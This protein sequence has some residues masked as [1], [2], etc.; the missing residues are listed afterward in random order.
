MLKNN[1]IRIKIRN[2][3]LESA[4]DILRDLLMDVDQDFIKLKYTT[5]HK[6]QNSLD[7]SIFVDFLGSFASGIVN[8]VIN[9]FYSKWHLKNNINSSSKERITELN[10]KVNKMMDESSSSHEELSHID[11]EVSNINMTL[12]KIANHTK[13]NPNANATIENYEFKMYI[14]HGAVEKIVSNLPSPGLQVPNAIKETETMKEDDVITKICPHC[15]TVNDG[16]AVYCKQC[17]EKVE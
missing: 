3:H 9:N 4:N 8:N 16:D 7:I 14:K 2:F 6:G 10:L 15:G 11:E 17:G 13:E 5:I 12:D 1:D